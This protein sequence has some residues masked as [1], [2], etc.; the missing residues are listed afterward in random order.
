MRFFLGCRNKGSIKKDPRLSKFN[1]RSRRF[2]SIDEAILEKRLIYDIS[3]YNKQL[4][5]N[6]ITNFEVCY[7]QQL[8]NIGSIV[9][10]FVGID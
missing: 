5:I 9:K 7:N 1:Y 10:E 6:V 3:R 8:C 4:T 2:Y